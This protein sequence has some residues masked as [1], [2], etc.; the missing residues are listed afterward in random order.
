MNESEI[1]LISKKAVA[2]FDIV[3]KKKANDYFKIIESE[4]RFDRL[5]SIYFDALNEQLKGNTLETKKLLNIISSE[6]AD[7]FIVRESKKILE[8]L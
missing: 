1:N 2:I 6:K 5:E 3:I 4:F 7:I 8:G